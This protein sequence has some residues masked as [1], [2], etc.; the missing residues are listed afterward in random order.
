MISGRTE[1][2]IRPAAVSEG[3]VTVRGGPPTSDQ[4][5]PSHYSRTD[6][7]PDSN[8]QSI[9]TK[10]GLRIQSLILTLFRSV[11]AR[12]SESAKRAGITTGQPRRQTR[13]MVQ[14]ATWDQFTTL[15]RIKALCAYHAN[16]LNRSNC[17]QAR[18][19]CLI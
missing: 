10:P 13:C 7:R 2:R 8:A 5:D 17:R 18:Y 16:V 15:I 11:F 1:K 19:K 4:W 12:E 6:H 3:L 9:Y 14:V